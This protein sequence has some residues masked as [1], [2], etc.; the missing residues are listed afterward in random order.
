MTRQKLPEWASRLHAA[1]RRAPEAP[2]EAIALLIQLHE[3]AASADAETEHSVLQV[4]V[5]LLINQRTQLGL[6]ERL[7]NRL[8][9]LCPD[10]MHHENLAQVHRLRGDEAA[11]KQAEDAALRAP[12]LHR[13]PEF[14]AEYEKVMAI[15]EAAIPAPAPATKKRPGRKRR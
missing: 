12:N 14:M 1:I 8:L 11:A 2:L 13:T 4:L 7:T 5:G 9:E 15:V 10:R 3:E 6:A